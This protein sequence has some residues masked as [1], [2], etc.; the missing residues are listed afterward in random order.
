MVREWME[1]VWRDGGDNGDRLSTVVFIFWGALVML[2]LVSSIIFAY[3]DGASKD[4]TSA[5]VIPQ[6]LYRVNLALEWLKGLIRFVRD[7]WK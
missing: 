6:I 1:V 7:C 5:T 4:K 2:S 3:A